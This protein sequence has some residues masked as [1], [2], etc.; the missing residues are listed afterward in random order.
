MHL[1]DFSD[2]LYEEEIIISFVDFIRKEKKF[3]GLESLKSQIQLDINVAKD[4][5]GL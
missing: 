5:L 3:D 2:N 1:F 4:L